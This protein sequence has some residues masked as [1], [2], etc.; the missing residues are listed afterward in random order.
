MSRLLGL[1]WRCD[2]CGQMTTDS[3]WECPSCK[4]E[5]C[6]NCFSAYMICN[7]CGE[8][9]TVEEMK[10]LSEEAGYEWEDG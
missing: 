4:E 8:G 7:K 9:K 10:A 1:T 5:T 6:E 2:T 3:P